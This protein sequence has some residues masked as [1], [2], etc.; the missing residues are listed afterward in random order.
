MSFRPLL[1]LSLVAI[2]LAG[3]VGVFELKEEE[4]IS[5]QETLLELSSDQVWEQSAE[6]PVGQRALRR[7]ELLQSWRDEAQWDALST[8]LPALKANDLPPERQP[9]LR[10]LQAY[11]FRYHGD[12]LAALA[13][14]PPFPQDMATLELQMQLY[15]QLK[16]V[17]NSTRTRLQ[18]AAGLNTEARRAEFQRAWNQLA[19]IDLQQLQDWR[20]RS[21]DEQW[22]GWLDLAL[23]AQPE[24]VP[25]IS[26]RDTMR[27]W[28]RNYPEH[29][30]SEWLPTVLAALQALR[31]N[32]QQI[33]ALLPLSGQLAPVGQAIRAGLMKHLRTLPGEA[34]ELMIYDTGDAAAEVTLLYQQAVAD[35][36]DRIIGPFAKSAVAQLARADVMTVPTLSL[37]YL[38]S[39][40]ANLEHLHQ[41]G[42]LPEDEAVQVAQRA[43]EDG[44]RSALAFVPNSNWGRRL[45]QSFTEAFE[46]GGGI[47]RDKAFYF[48]RASDHTVQIKDSLQLS[49][50]EQRQH[51]LEEVLGQE[52]VSRPSRRQDIDMVF[53]ASSPRNARLFKPQLDF[54]YAQDLPVY[55]T[56]HIYTGVPSPLQDQDLDDIRF[57]DAP[58]ILRESL[59]QELQHSSIAKQLPRFFALGA[60]AGLL[61]MNLSYLETRPNTVLKGWTGRLSVLPGRRVFRTLDWAYFRQGQVIPLDS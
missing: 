24:Q 14:L 46:A 56:S 38:D 36:A 4:E 13:V 51:R 12:H 45:Y 20:E 18:R 30:G 1:P 26:P 55:T 54:Y 11:V 40:T 42:L 6:L 22:R 2:L 23:L 49:S 25:L 33:A 29:P 60:D 7:L 34:P 31:P 58:M 53:L 32:I 10:L 59:R 61:A 5:P 57:C 21:Q 17:E 3:C 27:E 19:A 44:H 15:E 41:F 16:D 50:G 39:G 37:N 47:L 28:R 35:G 9:E 52:V 48:A 43:L 8:W